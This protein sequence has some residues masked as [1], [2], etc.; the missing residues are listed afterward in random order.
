MPANLE[1]E[2][3][4]LLTWDVLAQVGDLPTR[5]AL[6]NTR[7]VQRENEPVWLH[8]DAILGRGNPANSSSEM[9]PPVASQMALRSGGLG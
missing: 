2:P 7:R 4:W 5:M 9:A 3:Q 8:H 6:K 1:K